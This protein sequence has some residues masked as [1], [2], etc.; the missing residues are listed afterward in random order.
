MDVHDLFTSESVVEF[1]RRTAEATGPGQQLLSQYRQ[2]HA[3]Q[4][5]DAPRLQA[6]IYALED[7]DLAAATDDDLWSRLCALGFI[8]CPLQPSRYPDRA[9][10]LFRVVT[11]Q[12]TGRRCRSPPRRI[13]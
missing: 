5:R 1:R 13:V 4:L 6:W 2:D 8:E 3:N 7:G 9:V 10:F 11:P 12:S